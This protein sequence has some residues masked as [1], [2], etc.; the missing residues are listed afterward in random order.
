ALADRA[1]FILTLVALGAGALT[2]I[3]WLSL[4]AGA[5][6]A[7]E[8]LVTVLV[9]ACPHALGLAIPLVIAISTTLA[10][11]SRL[12]VRERRG[13]EDARNL[14]AIVFDKTGT[15]TRGEFGVVNTATSDGLPAEEALRLAAAVERDSEHMIA[16]GIVRSAE[17]R[18]LSISPAQ[19]FE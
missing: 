10:A 11:H 3:V 15:L 19:K 2:L 5:A 12:V 9:I 14:N 6:F 17:E 16:K 4:H 13:L 8:R 1:A 18:K 7:I